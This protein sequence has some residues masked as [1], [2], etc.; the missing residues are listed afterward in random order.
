MDD[1]LPFADGRLPAAFER[2]S[3]VVEPGAALAYDPAEW[4]GAVVVLQQG[5]V[6]LESVDGGRQ[7]FERGA[8]LWFDGL[9]IRALR[10]PGEHAAVLIAVARRDREPPS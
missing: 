3:V 1:E 6:E 2:R 4:T 8:V 9:P 5:V 7:R 10:N